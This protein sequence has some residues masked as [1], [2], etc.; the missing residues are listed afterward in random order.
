MIVEST[1]GTRTE[2]SRQLFEFIGIRWVFIKNNYSNIKNL[3]NPNSNMNGSNVYHLPCAFFC[4][5]GEKS[6][7]IY[8]SSE[9]QEPRV[10]GVSTKKQPDDRP[11]VPYSKRTRTILFQVK[12][13]N[14]YSKLILIAIKGLTFQKKRVRFELHLYSMDKCN[15]DHWPGPWLYFRGFLK[16][17]KA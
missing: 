9:T 11:L 3:L 12:V 6:F 15:L 4:W 10:C 8:S 5:W 13:I 17:K 16:M 1:L 2:I 7:R 14:T